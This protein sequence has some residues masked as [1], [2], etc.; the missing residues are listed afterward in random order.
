MSLTCQKISNI[1]LPYACCSNQISNFSDHVNRMKCRFRVLSHSFRHEAKGDIAPS[2]LRARG[3]G[4]GQ[5]GTSATGTLTASILQD[6]FQVR[7]QFARAWF[8]CQKL[9]L[10]ASSRQNDCSV[11]RAN[12]P[13]SGML[14]AAACGSVKIALRPCHFRGPVTSLQPLRERSLTTQSRCTSTAQA[15]LETS[16]RPAR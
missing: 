9:M 3:V 2:M 13:E 6:T 8:P 7:D 1:V 15:R 5:A 12:K 4:V 16:G 14:R 11:L 10:S